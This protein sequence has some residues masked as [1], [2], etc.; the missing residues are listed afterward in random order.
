[1]ERACGP[2]KINFRLWKFFRFFAWGILTDLF[3]GGT[4]KNQDFF[5]LLYGGGPKGEFKRGGRGFRLGAVAWEPFF[6]HTKGGDLKTLPLK[7]GGRGGV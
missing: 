2:F 3:L 5:F 6:F 1:M 7:A 4:K